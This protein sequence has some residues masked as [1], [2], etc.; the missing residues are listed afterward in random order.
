VKRT[1][2]P[3]PAYIKPPRTGYDPDVRLRAKTEQSKKRVQ[4]KRACRGR[5]SADS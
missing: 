4:S 1:P 3:K 2:K 5:F